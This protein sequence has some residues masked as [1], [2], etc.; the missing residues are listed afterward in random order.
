MSANRRLPIGLTIATAI[1]LVILIVLGTWQLQRLAWKTE[2]LARI[3]AAKTAPVN[4]LEE[5]LAEG[6][7]VEFRRVWMLCPAS[8]FSRQIELYGLVDSQSVRR[9]LIACPTSTGSILVDQGYVADTVSAR[10]GPPSA[11][12]IRIEGILRKPDKPGPFNPATERDGLW[13]GRDILAMAKALGAGNPAPVFL[14]ASAPVRPE[15]Q[16]LKPAPVPAGIPNRHLEYAL[17]WFGLAGAL[18][19][20]YA[21]MLWRRFKAR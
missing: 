9:L 18:L 4:A 21:A 8:A 3:E 2:L 19:A 1:S 10:P 7:D 16:A 6:G 5:V 13:Y 20:I 15:W 14:F 11:G 12:L 17:T